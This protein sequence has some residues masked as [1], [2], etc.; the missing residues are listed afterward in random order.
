MG[1]K[2]HINFL[3]LHNNLAEMFN[4]FSFEIKNAKKTE[5]LRKEY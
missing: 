2:L 1:A 5:Y 3:Y 4:V